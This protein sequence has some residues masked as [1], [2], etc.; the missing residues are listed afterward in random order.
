MVRSLPETR[1]PLACALGRWIN[2][3][4]GQELVKT[5]VRP[6]LSL[7]MCNVLIDAQILCLITTLI[8]FEPALWG[9][10]CVNLFIAL[11]YI[12]SHI[13]LAYVHMNVSDPKL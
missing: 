2:Q 13:R 8:W 12:V 11:F 1:D 4:K 9:F 5:Y 10:F 7:K 3:I 6:D